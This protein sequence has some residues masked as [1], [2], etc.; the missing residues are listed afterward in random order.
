MPKL[1][2]LYIVNVAYGFGLSVVFLGLLLWMDVAGLRHLIFQ[3]SMGWVAAIMMIVMNG[4]VFAGVQFAIAVMRLAEDP[5]G[6]KG[7]S[8]APNVSRLMPVRITTKE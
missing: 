2:K 6:P 1:V 4:V 8:R 7:G 3:S 5:E